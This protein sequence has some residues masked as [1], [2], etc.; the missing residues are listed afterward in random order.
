VAK[1]FQ[2]LA[3]WQRCVELSDAVFRITARV[4]ERRF[5]DQIRGAAAAAP[6]LIAEGFARYTPRDFAHYLR[7]ARGELAEV[8]SHLV[9]GRARDYFTADEFET[10]STTARRAMGT[11]T[12]LLKAKLKQIEEESH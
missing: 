4:S 5:R 1:Q 3:A 8:Q 12:N 2:D 6:A 7:M 9:I 11:T 10:T